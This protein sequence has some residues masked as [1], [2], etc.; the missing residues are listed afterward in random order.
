MWKYSLGERHTANLSNQL[1]VVQ[2][3]RVPLQLQEAKQFPHFVLRMKDEVLVADG[4]TSVLPGRLTLTE[5]GLH[6]AAPL[7]QT[8]PVAGQVKARDGHLCTDGEEPNKEENLSDGDKPLENNAVIWKKLCLL[9]VISWSERLPG[10][11][12]AL[13]Q[14]WL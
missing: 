3:R 4:Q 9:S 5:H 13:A 8:V 2:H 10:R 7:G 14:I 11:H 6:G 1:F 12:V